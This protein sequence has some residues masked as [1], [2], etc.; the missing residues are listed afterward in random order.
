MDPQNLT[1]VLKAEALRQ[2]FSL[3]GAAPVGTLPDYERLLTWLDGGRAAGMTHFRRHLEAY[4]DPNRLLDGV[5]SVLMLAMN[6]RTVDPV[7]PGRGQGRIARYAW[8]TDYHVLI[9]R[10]LR[11]LEDFHRQ[12]VP[13]AEVRGIVDTAPF[14]ERAFARLAGLG[15]IGKNNMLIHPEL[16]SWLFLAALLSTEELVYDRPQERDL[17]AD[18][19]RCLDACP[20]GALSAPYTLDARRCI[21]Y[22]TQ[23]SEFPEPLR[24]A[25]G[26][27]LFGCDACQEVCPWN[28]QGP[29]S[30]SAEFFP[31]P[32]I[33]PAELAE[34]AALDEEQFRRRFRDTPLGRLRREGLRKNVTLVEDNQRDGSHG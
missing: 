15:G 29:Q 31:R 2:G 27:R 30:A 1:D 21:S 17:C 28:R 7:T 6:Y 33:N 14:F 26:D 25:V 9:R 34:I 8:G 18:C 32:G 4:R 16:G 23:R 11:R 13:S 10:K 3:A 5:R 22:L 12:H 19:R 24:P 20:T